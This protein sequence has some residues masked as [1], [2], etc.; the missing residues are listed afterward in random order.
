MGTDEPKNNV[1][2]YNGKHK[3]RV[4]GMKIPAN[5]FLCAFFMLTLLRCPQLT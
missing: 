3:R 4:L 5:L 1:R 2:Q